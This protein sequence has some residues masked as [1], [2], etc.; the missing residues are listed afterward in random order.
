MSKQ[1]RYNYKLKNTQYTT[2]HYLPVLPHVQQADHNSATLLQLWLLRCNAILLTIVVQGTVVLHNFVT[3]YYHD[4]VVYDNS[5]PQM[6]QVS[7]H[8][9]HT[10]IYI[11]SRHCGCVCKR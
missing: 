10:S 1:R 7:S 9:C 8:I 3:H 11:V 6:K 5:D 2:T 4:I